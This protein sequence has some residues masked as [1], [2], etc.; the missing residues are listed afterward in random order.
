MWP[1]ENSNAKTILSHTSCQFI[2]NIFNTNEL[3]NSF[4]VYTCHK[5]KKF[6]YCN[7]NNSLCLARLCLLGTELD[8]HR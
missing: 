6:I 2:S 3:Q 5:Y 8:L 1:L 7:A 4:L